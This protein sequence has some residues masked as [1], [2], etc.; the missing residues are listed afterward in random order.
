MDFNSE[1]AENKFISKTIF[2]VFIL[3]SVLAL[4][5]IFRAITQGELLRLWFLIFIPLFFASYKLSL[6]DKT[7]V[8][9]KI[10]Y[11]LNMFLIFVPVYFSN[12]L[13]AS[14][15]SLWGLVM[16]LM[17]YIVHKPSGVIFFCAVMFLYIIGLTG[18]DHTQL[19]F[20]RAKTIT[21]NIEIVHLI[22]MV[23]FVI[24]AMRRLTLLAAI[25][26]EIMRRSLQQEQELS[27]AKDIFLSNMS[28]ELRT[29]LNGIYGALQIVEGSDETEKAVMRV[30]KKSAQSLNRIVSDILDIQK[31]SNGKLEIAPQWNDAA[32]IFEQAQNLFMPLADIK[33]VTLNLTI[34]ASLPNELYCDELRLGQILNNLVGNAIKFTEQGSV[35]IDT[36]YE[37]GSL[38]VSIS[39]TGIGMDD[40]A[41]SHLFDRFTQAD[42]SL[43]KKYAGTGLGMAITKEL[44]ELMAGSIDVVSQL[45]QGT[46]FTVKLPLQ[47]RN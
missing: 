1:S 44:V 30:A 34:D 11:S 21:P 33:H 20:Y 26:T 4:I 39:D 45:G 27:K 37:D 16:A 18:F 41:L 42:S 7:R 32:A 10:L 6:F 19:P 25:P 43:S 29:P 17:V 46:T 22:F 12:G 36:R 38:I 14:I 3:I 8:F 15:T 31:L 47:G 28:H 9:A 35:S 2:L 13:L 23:V 40:I 24:Y 5:P